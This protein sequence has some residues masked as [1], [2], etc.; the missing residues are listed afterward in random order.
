MPSPAYALDGDPLLIAVPRPR[1]KEVLIMLQ[2]PIPHPPARERTYPSLPRRNAPAIASLVCTI[3]F[4]LAFYATPAWNIWT[5]F[6]PMPEWLGTLTAAGLT[7]L[8][9]ATILLAIVGLVRSF[10]R[11]QLRHTRW[12]AVVGLIFG[13]MWALGAYFFFG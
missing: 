6:A 4:P 2:T 13:I 5:H 8:P 12:Q 10:T 1:P 9:A 7:L 3:L 11:L